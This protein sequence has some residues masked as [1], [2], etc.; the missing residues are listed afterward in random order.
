M[1][2]YPV[3]VLSDIHLGSEY[4]RIRELNLFLEKVSCDLLILNGD[5]IDGWQL[6]KSG[7]HL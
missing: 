3:L 7:R 6:R 4:S 1:E 2:H 5:I